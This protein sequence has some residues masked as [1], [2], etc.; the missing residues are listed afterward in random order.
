MSDAEAMR[1]SR[2]AV[3]PVPASPRSTRVRLS[4]R[5]IAEARSSSSAHSLVRPRRPPVAGVLT[6]S[7]PPL[8]VTGADTTRLAWNF[9]D[10]SAIQIKQTAARQYLATFVV[11]WYGEVRAD[12]DQLA[13]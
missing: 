1:Y 5:R 8:F 10:V 4:P 2:S 9:H 3:F 7:S 11:D 13:G 12:S 6:R